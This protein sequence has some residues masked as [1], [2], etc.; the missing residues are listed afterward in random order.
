MNLHQNTWLTQPQ[1]CTLHM[2]LTNSLPYSSDTQLIH[3]HS[4]HTRATSYQYHQTGTYVNWDR[5]RWWIC[6][7]THTEHICSNAQ[8]HVFTYMYT[9]T[10]RHIESW[11]VEYQSTVMV[12]KTLLTSNPYYIHSKL[13]TEYS[14]RTRQQTGG[15]IKRLH[16]QTQ[17][18]PSKEQLQM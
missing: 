5:H 1:A 6:T 16:I 2:P 11:L 3:S 13:N 15:R 4:R 9:S 14:Y 12:H 10:R 7:T 17:G 8:P 18:W